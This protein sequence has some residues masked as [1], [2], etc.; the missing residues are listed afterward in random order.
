M[1]RKTHS[2]LLKSAAKIS[3]RVTKRSRLAPTFSIEINEGK[4]LHTLKGD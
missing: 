4:D 2:V 3:P 1:N